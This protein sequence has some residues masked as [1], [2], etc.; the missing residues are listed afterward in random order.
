MSKVDGGAPRRWLEEDS[1]AGDARRQLLQE[2]SELRPWPEAR[3]EQV[4]R[5]LEERAA[6]RVRRRLGISALALAAS[7][8]A[9]A[10]VAIRVRGPA[11]L[12]VGDLGRIALVDHPRITHVPTDAD[13]MLRVEAGAI[14][15][16]INHRPPGRP[17]SVE[18]P[19]L[20]VVVVGTRFS[21]RVLPGLTEVAVRE[22]RV[23]VESRGQAVFVG[24][25]QSVRSDDPRF[26]PPAPPPAPTAAPPVQGPVRLE[27][28]SIPVPECASLRSSGEREACVSRVATGSG[29]AAQ[30]A[31][32]SQALAQRDRGNLAGAIAD[33]HAYQARFANGLFA[34]EVGFELAGE[35]VDA[36]RYQE[37][38]QAT[39]ALERAYPDDPRTPQAA[40]VC[41]RV[42]REQLRQP[43]SAAELAR[44]YV[45]STDPGVREAALYQ[46]GLSEEAAGSPDAE[47]TWRSYLEGFPSGPHADDARAHLK[48]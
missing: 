11:T 24:A 28:R 37:A 7:I 35:L 4:L 36:G 40:L 5:Q 46:F 45:S 43:A 16:Q 47:A 6:G 33:L 38:V 1:S 44:K 41:A 3:R 14:E 30:N 12:P 31:L 19:Q 23:R 10:L 9:V 13:P 15:A 48:R 17:F 32:V 27:R 18:T 25:G 8:A 39:K 21:V 20:R 26:A 34:P 22:G 42:L 2:G 29:L